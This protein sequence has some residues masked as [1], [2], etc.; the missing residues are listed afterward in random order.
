MT[1]RVLTLLFA[2]CLTSAAEAMP[3][4]ACVPDEDTIKFNRHTVNNASVQHAAGNTDLIVLTCPFT[5]F[6]PPQNDW[7]LSLTYRDST[8]SNTA[9]FVRAQL[10]RMPIGGANPVLITTVNSNSSTDT[11]VSNARSPN[12]TH[13]FNFLSNVYWVRVELRR[14]TTN[15]IVI[16]HSVALGP[17]VF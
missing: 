16:L 8:G 3:G 10:Y 2:L 5:R 12:F 15:Q 1:A 9:A 7:T 17:P 11:V 13:A 4:S 14:T 6:D